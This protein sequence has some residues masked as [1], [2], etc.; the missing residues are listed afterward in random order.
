MTPGRP[1][2]PR[3]L[4]GGLLL[5][6]ATVADAEELIEFNARIHAEEGPRDDSVAI[7]VDDLMRR[8]H[9]TFTPADF[10]VVEDTGS[11]KIVSCLN[12]ISQTWSYQDIAV[13]VGRI[14]LVSTAEDYRRRGLIR[15]QLRAVHR[16]SA[17]RGELVQGITGVP[18]FYRRFGYEMAIEIGAG[19]AG[20][21]TRV[22]EKLDTGGLTVRPATVEDAPFLVRA[23]AMARSRYIVTDIWDE[24]AWRLNTA[25]RSEGS[26]ANL[27][28]AVVEDP[29]GSPA[30]LLVHQ[31]E[32]RRGQIRAYA[33]EV[34]DGVAWEPAT[35]AVLA[36]LRGIEREQASPVVEV[37]LVAGSDHPAYAVVP[38][39]LDRR[40]ALYAWYVRVADVSAF[41][42]KVRPALQ[43]RLDA[44]PMAGCEGSLRINLG[45]GGVRIAIERGTIGAVGDWQPEHFEDGDVLFPGTVF[46]QVLFGYRSFDEVRRGFPDCRAHSDRAHALVAALFPPGPSLVLGLE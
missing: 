44:S 36:Y 35:A 32:P 7:W 2:L 5:R 40:T 41:L 12:L 42:R 13:G 26:I 31:P 39:L 43:D 38:Q 21:I 6:S 11:G 19:R 8:E 18:Y 28:V 30:G 14:E 29:A 16:W 37:A 25:G 15:E 17:D 45:D 23:H 27:G 4:G 10:T 1:L 34:A 3:D 33:F 46:L 24:A 22:P 9:P 20:P